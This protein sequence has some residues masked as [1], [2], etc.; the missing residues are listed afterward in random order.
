[1]SLQL[2]GTT[3]VIGPVNEGFVTATGSTTARNLDDRF[4]DVVNVKDF[5]ADPSGVVNSSTAINNALTQANANG[6]GIVFWM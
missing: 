3:G 6:G 2:N 4:A 5:D 1:M